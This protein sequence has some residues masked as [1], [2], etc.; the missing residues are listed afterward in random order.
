MVDPLVLA[1]VAG[2]SEILGT[3]LLSVEAIKLPNLRRFRETI[4]K[5]PLERLNPQ[6]HFVE[7][8]SE[9]T[10]AGAIWLLVILAFLFL[11]GASCIYAFL[12]WN[13]IGIATAWRVLTHFVPG[14]AWIA[15][16]AAFPA[17]LVLLFVAGAIGLFLYSVPVFLLTCAVA[18]LTWIET[19]TT[20]GIVGMLGFFFF[21]VGAV[22]RMYAELNGAPLAR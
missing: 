16:V 21:S 12:R 18:A 20:S 15:Q 8:A 10:P 22:L 14:P 4:L 1:A 13:G 9:E 7:E 17:G 11:A 19:R 6:I 3:F 5:T 2:C